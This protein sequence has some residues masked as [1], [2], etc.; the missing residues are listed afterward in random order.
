MFDVAPAANGNQGQELGIA[1]SVQAS[2]GCGKTLQLRQCVVQDVGQPVTVLDQALN[3]V[4]PVW[5]YKGRAPALTP[6]RVK[7]LRQRAGAGEKKTVLAREFG[8]SRQTLYA[9]LDAVPRNPAPATI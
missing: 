4:E 9:N 5:V 2:A 1:S 6:E 3:Q 7:E 8:I